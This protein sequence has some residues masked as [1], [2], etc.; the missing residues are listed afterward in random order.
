MKGGKIMNHNNHNMDNSKCKGNE[1]ER[2]VDHLVNLVERQT[3]TERH[4]E[5]HSDIS[6][7]PENIEHAK[8]LNQKRENEIQNIKNILAHGENYNNDTIENTEKRFRY[9]EGY[10]NHNADHMDEQAFRNAKE[11]QQHRKDQLDQ[12]K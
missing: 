5:E 9:A 12:M 4:L 1:N 10:L 3:R 2:R 8:E 6:K 11:R 7:S